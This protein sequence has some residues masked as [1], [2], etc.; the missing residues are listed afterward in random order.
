MMGFETTFTDRRLCTA[1]VGWLTF[2]ARPT[3]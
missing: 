3:G 1:I 2:G